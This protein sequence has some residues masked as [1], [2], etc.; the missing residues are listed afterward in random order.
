MY[1]LLVNGAILAGRLH[2]KAKKALADRLLM[3]F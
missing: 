3:L 1:A 2:G